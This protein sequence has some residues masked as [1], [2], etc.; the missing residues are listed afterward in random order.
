[1]SYFLFKQVKQ[2]EKA[3]EVEPVPMKY[4]KATN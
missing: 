3:S 1:M 4:V 2:G